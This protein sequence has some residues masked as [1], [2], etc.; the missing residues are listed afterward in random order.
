M[1]MHVVELQSQ[2]D[3]A[4]I[5]RRL[6]WLGGERVA[7]VLPWDIRFLSRKLDFD[8]LYREAE[9]Y[10]L[11]VAIVSADPGRRRLARES[12][13]PSFA[14]V[15]A[16]QRASRWRSRSPRQVRP[17]P[18]HWWDEEIDLR[19]RRVRPRPRWLDWVKLGIRLVIFLVVLV[20][21]AGSAYI[22]VPS[23]VV[24]LVPA[25]EE[26]TTVVPVSVDL[27]AEGVDHTVGLIPA[28]RV[29]VE[30]EGYLEVE[31]T[32]TMVV[33]A[34][35]AAGMVLFTN[36]LAQD[37]VVPAGTV[38]R[39]SSTSYPIRFRT[40]ADVAISAG[41]QATAPIEALEDGVGN[42]GAFQINQVEGVAASAVRVINPEPT[43]G[44]EPR[45]VRVV[46]DADYEQAR[47]Q[48]MQQLLDQ[49][50]VDMGYLLEPTEFVPRQSLR[51]EAVPKQAYTRFVTE[52]ADTVGLNMRLLVSGL[53]A[54]ADNAEAVAYTR[55]SYSLPP[56]YALVSASFE[57]GEVAEEDIGPGHFTFFVTAF[58]YAAATID[59]DA[60]A[61]LIRGQRVVD[62]RER[63]LAEFPLIEEP[64]IMLWPEWPEHLKWLERLP[65]L[66]LRITVRVVPQGLAVS[67]VTSA[68]R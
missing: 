10:Q 4:S 8:L 26:F 13:F 50:P 19:P 60:A 16:A 56:G 24:T 55:L 17:L 15:K 32:G 66:P 38:V 68:A 48:L 49:A 33:V 34:G 46:T 45:E 58:G 62:A 27:E 36:L 41:G 14:S 6:S 39:T 47:K 40:T 23:G 44:A 22:V 25:G 30:I 52:Q 2:D 29:G 5:Q 43:T 42:V 11:E 63:L 35:R 1:A 59:K 18:R 7:L 37:Y 67:P 64:Y 21:V 9:R 20:I 28:R 12:G 65:L 51:V 57:I 61:A 53:A 54:D 3:L 31:T